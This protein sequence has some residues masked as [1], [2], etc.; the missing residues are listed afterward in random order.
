MGT[1]SA[2]VRRLSPSAA[3]ESALACLEAG[4]LMETAD[5]RE[6]TKGRLNPE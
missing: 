5:G 6:D 2:L 4:R 1:L 3:T